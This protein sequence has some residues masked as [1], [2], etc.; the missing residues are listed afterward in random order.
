MTGS[1]ETKEFQPSMW[2]RSQKAKVN[3]E[4]ATGKMGERCCRIEV[5]VHPRAPVPTPLLLTCLSCL[6]LQGEGLAKQVTS[7]L[8]MRVERGGEPERR[9]CWA[10]RCGA[11]SP[12]PELPAPGWSPSLAP[13]PF[14]CPNLTYPFLPR[15]FPQYIAFTRI[16]I[17]GS[18]SRK[19]LLTTGTEQLRTKSRVKVEDT[20]LGK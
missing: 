9:D 3:N 20:F 18:T 15:T 11:V 2:S 17:L 10:Q 1:Q 13:A 19:F 4:W 5:G 12:V 16:L 8:K 7:T 14:S 6:L